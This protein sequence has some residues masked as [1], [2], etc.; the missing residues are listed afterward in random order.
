MALTTFHYRTAFY[1][2]NYLLRQSFFRPNYQSV[3]KIPFSVYPQVWSTV[4]YIDHL[5]TKELHCTL[6]ITASMISTKKHQ[7][8]TGLNQNNLWLKAYNIQ[9][10]NNV[11]RKFSFLLNSVTIFHALINNHFIFSLYNTFTYFHAKKSFCC[12]NTMPY[13]YK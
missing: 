7:M 5:E 3:V 10:D 1:I 11:L 2:H 4:E 6:V 9:L 8:R 12:T 13:I